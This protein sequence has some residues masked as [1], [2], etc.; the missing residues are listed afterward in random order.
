[1]RIEVH[2]FHHS[3]PDD[4]VTAALKTITT[5]LATL[6]AK[7]DSLNM[8]IDDFK[9]QVQAANDKLATEVAS[10]TTVEQSVETLVNGLNAQLVALK[11]ELAK[12]LASGGTVD[13]ETVI[14]A[15]NAQVDA[16]QAALDKLKAAVV[17]GTPAA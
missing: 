12:A 10:F 15:L 7:G 3:V 4:S 11:D 14:A 8:K 2:H 1:L 6:L 5:Q 9:T 16:N 13:G 17:A